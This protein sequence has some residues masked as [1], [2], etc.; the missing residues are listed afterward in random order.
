MTTTLFLN[1]HTYEV[2][3]SDGTVREYSANLIAENMLTQVDDEG[4]STTLLSSIINHEKD[5][6][7]AVEK[8]DG[9]VTTNRGSRRMRKTTAGW[10]L[11]VQWGDKSE[12]W[13][14]L[15]DLK[16]SH[17]VEV[18]EY[19]RARKIDDEPAF[20]WWVPYTLRKRDVILSAVKSR[21]RKT[22]H[23]YGIEIPTSIEHAFE[24]DDRN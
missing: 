12:S 18:A 9:Y 6:A 20:M 23:K 2:E 17:P 5:P 3:F 1:S 22:S 8:E 19:A 7:I 15:K 11:L 14:P 4:Y 16:E 13:I 21:I 10:R 24:I